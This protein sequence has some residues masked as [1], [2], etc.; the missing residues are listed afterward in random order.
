MRRSILKLD[1]YFYK[2]GAIPHG[3]C[4]NIV[5]DAQITYHGVLILRVCAMI[6]MIYIA[7]IWMA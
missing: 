6:Y 3:R 4:N 1:F 5:K 7:L 2:Y